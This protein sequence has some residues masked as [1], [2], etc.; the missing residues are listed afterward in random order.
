MNPIL[1]KLNN[2]KPPGNNLISRL[3]GAKNPDALYVDMMNN[4]E[5]FR[6]FVTENEGKSPE[7]IA[8][9][10]GVNINPILQMLKK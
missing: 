10:Y 4:N 6:N 1:T 5:Q 8:R 7:E 3:M 2:S 9:K